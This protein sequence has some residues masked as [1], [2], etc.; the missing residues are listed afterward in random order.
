[1]VKAIRESRDYSEAFETPYII[2][3]GPWLNVD[4]TIRGLGIRHRE[5]TF[6]KNWSE[7][8]RWGLHRLL[9]GARREIPK[10]VFIRSQDNVNIIG[11]GDGILVSGSAWPFVKGG[12]MDKFNDHSLVLPL[13]VNPLPR[14]VVGIK[15]VIDSSDYLPRKLNVGKFMSDAVSD[16]YSNLVRD[17]VQEIF[18]RR[19]GDPLMLIEWLLSKYKVSGEVSLIV[20]DAAYAHLVSSDGLLPSYDML[21]TFFEP[22]DF[23]QIV[24]IVTNPLMA[25][26]AYLRSR[27]EY[28]RLIV[29]SNPCTLINQGEIINDIMKHSNKYLLIIIALGNKCKDSID[30][31]TRGGGIEYKVINY[32]PNAPHWTHYR[33]S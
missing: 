16:W 7:P 33:L 28:G 1:M 8:M 14:D 27:Y 9:S 12:V 21:P 18:F 30:S 5:P 25:I 10:E 20:I 11:K 22:R 4:D 26:S 23:D 24:D 17:A 15:Y 3:L 13:Y 19:E 6:N 2:R 31:L 29:V 32:D